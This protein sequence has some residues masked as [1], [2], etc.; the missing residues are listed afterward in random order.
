MSEPPDFTIAIYL[1]YISYPRKTGT[2]LA[3]ANSLMQGDHGGQQLHFLDFI[4]EFQ[5]YCPNCSAISAQFTAA[6]AELGRQWNNQIVISK[7]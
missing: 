6:Q 4:F 5:Q 2:P 1:S 7:L 3:I